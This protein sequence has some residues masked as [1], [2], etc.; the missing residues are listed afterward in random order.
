M[1]R[2][3]FLLFLGFGKRSR[4]ILSL[5]FIIL[6]ALAVIGIIVWNLPASG[7]V[8]VNQTLNV[9]VDE[10]TRIDVSNGSGPQAK[11]TNKSDINQLL[12]PFLKVEIRKISFFKTSVL[13]HQLQEHMG[14]EGLYY[15]IYKN[16]SPY[17]HMEYF[18]PQMLNICPDKQ[19]ENKVL[20][21][22]ATVVNVASIND[23]LTKYHINVI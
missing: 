18:K 22:T 17:V 23:I 12:S 19:A 2:K 6:A 1:K 3:S 20:Y 8:T 5:C 11:V 7:P 21:S 9:S 13:N 14:S 10:I 15:V 4:G 16:G